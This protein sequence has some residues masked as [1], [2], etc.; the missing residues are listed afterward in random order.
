[1]WI[2]TVENYSFRPC[3]RQNCIVISRALWNRKWCSVWRNAMAPHCLIRTFQKS[4]RPMISTASR[5]FLTSITRGCQ[6]CRPGRIFMIFAGLTCCAVVTTMWFTPRSFLIRRDIQIAVLHL[7]KCLKIYILNSLRMHQKYMKYIL[8]Y[9]IIPSNPTMVA[10][11]FEI[12]SWI[13]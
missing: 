5:I 9:K 12:S 2:K 11:N 8:L 13:R 10:E 6:Y 3:P 7:K 1:M 4:A